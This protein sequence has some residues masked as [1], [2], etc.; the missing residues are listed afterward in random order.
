MKI[1]KKSKRDIAFNKLVDANNLKKAKRAK[2][3]ERITLGLSS[4]VTNSIVKVVL[5]IIA[6]CW[7]GYWV[8]VAIYAPFKFL[9]GLW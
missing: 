9:K 6:A 5:F 8:V 3:I 2:R 4:F 7:V 1:S